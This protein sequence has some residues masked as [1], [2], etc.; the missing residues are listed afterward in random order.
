M[1]SETRIQ[2]I[3]R[4]RN[5]PPLKIIPRK[6]VGIVVS[7]PDDKALPG[8]KNYYVFTKK[9]IEKAVPKPLPTYKTAEE[10]KAEKTF[11]AY[12]HKLGLQ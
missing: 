7:A 10:E 12:L 9:K 5:I 2:K 4:E 3:C 11:R 8:F 6:P 1:V